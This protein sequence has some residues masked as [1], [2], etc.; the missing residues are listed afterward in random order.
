MIKYITLYDDIYT[1]H[2]TTKRGGRN[3]RYNINSKLPKSIRE[4]IVDNANT[5]TTTKL[6]KG[7]F[8]KWEK[9]R[10]NN[11]NEV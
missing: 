2:T 11:E 9:I 10:E 6:E 7:L 1:V 8:I 4:F 5:S 3:R